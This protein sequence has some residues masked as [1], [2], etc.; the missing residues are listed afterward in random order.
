MKRADARIQGRADIG[1]GAGEP[2][3]VSDVPVELT[4]KQRELFDALY[5]DH[6]DFVFRNLRRLGV[7][8]SAIDDGLQDVYLVALR[9]IGEFRE[10]TY[11]KAWLFA[12]VA[13]VAG[14]H[15]RSQRRRG[16]RESGVP[17]IEESVEGGALGPFEQTAQQQARR[18]LH[19]FLQQLDD[20]RRAAFVLAELEQLT[21]PE[22]AQAL[23]ANVNTVYSWLRAARGEFVRMLESVRAAEA[24]P[25]G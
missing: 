20:N 11:A 17:L 10:G 25:G 1:W 5:R 24:G 16:N 18:L 2:R 21:A 4:P 19:A 9:R 6:F 15:R 7:A 12:I 14:N 3:S 23:S 13:R 8:E 22:I